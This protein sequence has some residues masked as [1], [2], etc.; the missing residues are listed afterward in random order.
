MEELKRKL[1]EAGLNLNEIIKLEKPEL[2]PVLE[3]L[4]SIDQS[5]KTLAE[6]EAPE[7]E[8]RPEVQKIE[9]AGLETITLKGDKGE[10]P[11]DEELVALIKPLI[12]E[13]VKGDKGDTPTASQ[14]LKIIRPLIP[15]VKDGETPSDERLLA[16]ITPLI[17]PPLQGSPDSPIEIVEKL[18]SLEGD[19]RLD[20]K[21]V[22]GLEEELTSIRTSISSIPRGGGSRR[23]FQ[24]YVDD[25]SASCD[26]A[27]KTFYL[28]RAPLKAE[29]TLVWGTDFPVIL[30]PTIDF[31]V[32]NKVLTLTSSVP[33]PSSGASLMVLVFA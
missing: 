6:K 19:E 32:A 22:K 18:E 21:A 33:A 16:L 5:L 31:T 8:E 10:T 4:E 14:L 24:P 9:I 23:V 1:S 28:S 15:E 30:R 25:L 7:P 20:K 12:P 17:P 3:V 26:G 29:A 27:N 13:P 2:I 11:T